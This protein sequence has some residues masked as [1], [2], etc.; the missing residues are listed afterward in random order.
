[1]AAV[2]PGALYLYFD[3]KEALIAGISERDRAEFQHRFE[4]LAEAPDL[5]QALEQL[6]AQYFIEEPAHK[7]LLCIEIGLEATRN[8][9]VG[10]IYR[11]V[12]SYCRQ[13]FETL[14]QRLKD[15]GRIAPA[16]EIPLLARV[17][18]TI[19]DGLFWRRATDPNFDLKSVLPAVLATLKGLINPLASGTE[20]AGRALQKAIQ[21]DVR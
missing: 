2:S 4:G 3:S 15:E 20:S 19:G 16:L 5:M 10:E 14:F 12:D 18:A 9:R 17:F 21:E 13:S 11:S 8:P 6:A 7:Q 1:E